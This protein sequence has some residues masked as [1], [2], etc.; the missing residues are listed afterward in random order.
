M[1][2]LRVERHVGEQ[3]V[4]HLG[5]GPGVAVLDEFAGDEILEIKPAALMPSGR[6]LRHLRLLHRFFVKTTFTI[7]VND[8]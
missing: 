4:V 1:E 6:L 7:T 5:D 3:H 2:R 8:R